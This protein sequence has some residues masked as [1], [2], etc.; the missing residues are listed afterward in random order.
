[1]QSSQPHVL[2]E[3]DRV[4]TPGR[5]AEAMSDA[6]GAGFERISLDLIYGANGETDAD[7]EASVRTALDLEPEHISAYALIVEPGTRLHARVRAHEVPPRTTTRSPGATSSPTTCSTRPGWPGT[8]SR[9]GASPA[10]TT[11]ATGAGTTGG[12][13]APARTRIWTADAGGT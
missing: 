11:S 2:A 5:V 7:W 10:A 8:R 12:E 6:R 9:T 1:M 13:R 3:L 4:H